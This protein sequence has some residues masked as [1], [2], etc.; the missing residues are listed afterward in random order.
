VVHVVQ[1]QPTHQGVVVTEPAFQRHRQV[2]DLDAHLALGQFGQDRTA[3][4][5]SRAVLLTRFWATLA[6]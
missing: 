3:A 4:L 6:R 2:R 5:P 1:A